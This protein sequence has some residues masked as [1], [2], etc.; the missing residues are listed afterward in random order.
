MHVCVCVCC[1]SETECVV[2]SFSYPCLLLPECVHSSVTVSRCLCLFVCVHVC[3]CETA[4]VHVHSPIIADK[5]SRGIITL[6]PLSPSPP[7]HFVSPLC[8]DSTV[9]RSTPLLVSQHIVY[10]LTRPY[11][12]N[13]S[14]ASSPPILIFLAPKSTHPAGADTSG[15][16]LSALRQRGCAREP[17]PRLDKKETGD[18]DK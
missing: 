13:P 14:P 18:E 4:V 17:W 6:L 7:S 10:P 12:Q 5:Q 8:D 3:V 11:A 15:V 9:C 16:M 2:C 1:V